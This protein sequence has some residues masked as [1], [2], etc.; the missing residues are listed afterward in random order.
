[1]KRMKVSCRDM[2]ANTMATLTA[3][4]RTTH[5]A[6]ILV[7]PPNGHKTTV[8]LALAARDSMIENCFAARERRTRPAAASI[9]AVLARGL[10]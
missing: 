5:A 7:L 6:F 9:S 10:F 4:T 1:M 8:Q 3:Q 2:R